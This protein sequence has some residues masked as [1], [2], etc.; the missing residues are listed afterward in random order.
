MRVGSAVLNQTWHETL[1]IPAYP[2]LLATVARELGAVWSPNQNVFTQVSCMYQY[3]FAYTHKKYECIHIETL[4]CVCM[5]AF[6]NVYVCIYEKLVEGKRQALLWQG[7]VFSFQQARAYETVINLCLR[8]VPNRLMFWRPSKKENLS[9]CLRN[10]CVCSPECLHQSA[11]QY[12]VMKCCPQ[13]QPLGA[14]Q[15]VT[16]KST[17]QPTTT[18]GAS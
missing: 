4:F 6:I 5:Y 2:F 8:I 17:L 1:N 13:A 12:G 10:H 15:R 9:S 3:A 18:G 16:T 14:L 7:I 11:E